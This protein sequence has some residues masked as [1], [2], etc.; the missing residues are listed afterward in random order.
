MRTILAYILAFIMPTLP[1]IAIV[2]TSLVIF[3]TDNQRLLEKQSQELEVQALKQSL[4][5]EFYHYT[6]EGEK[7]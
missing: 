1:I 5:S 2:I 6:Q 3:D 4:N 7:Q